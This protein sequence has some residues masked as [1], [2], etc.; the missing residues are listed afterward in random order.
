MSLDPKDPTYEPTAHAEG[1]CGCCPDLRKIDFTITEVCL[2]MHIGGKH[3]VR[4]KDD[5]EFVPCPKGENCPGWLC[6]TTTKAFENL[7]NSS[8]E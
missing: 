7:G 1:R 6:D 3:L 5:G 2:D 8:I 4:F